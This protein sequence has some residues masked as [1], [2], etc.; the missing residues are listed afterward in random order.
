MPYKCEKCNIRLCKGRIR[1][2]TDRFIGPMHF[3]KYRQ[4]KDIM[5]MDNETNSYVE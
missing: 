1:S 4:N 5:D 2:N 3:S